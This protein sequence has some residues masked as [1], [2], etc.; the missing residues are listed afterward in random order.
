MAMAKYP[1]MSNNSIDAT[2]S[3]LRQIECL[4]SAWWLKN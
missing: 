1:V 2:T 3:D 4:G